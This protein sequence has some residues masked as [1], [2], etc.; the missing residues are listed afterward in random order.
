MKRISFRT[1]GI[2]TLLVMVFVMTAMWSAFQRYGA[3]ADEV[4]SAARARYE[5]YLLADE[6]RQSSDDL[7]RLA[8]TYVMS[9]DPKWE[10][11][12]F[13][14]LDI[15][16]GKL[17]RPADY[18]RIYWDFRAADI[19]PARGTSPAAPLIDLMKKAG[20]SETELGK[21]KIAADNSDDLV[22][23][24]TIAM[25]LVKGLYPDA[26]GQFVVV[27]K[28]D[29]P[30]AQAM[31]HDEAYHRYKAKIMAPLDEFF[32]ALDQRT[33]RGVDA[34][35]EAKDYWKQVLV[36]TGCAG[37]LLLGIGACIAYLVLRSSV[38]A[39]MRVSKA[40]AAGDL[41]IEIKPQG[42]AEMAMLLGSLSDT[43]DVLAS[44]LAAEKAAREL[45][46]R[47]AAENARIKQALDVAAANVMLIDAER[48]IIYGNDSLR[49]MFGEAEV[50]I[51]KQMPGFEATALIGKPV[52]GVH[53]NPGQQRG[54][55]D[56]LKATETERMSIGRRTFDLVMTPIVDAQGARLGTVIEWR[57]LTNLLAAR[58]LEMRVAGEN[59]QI[60]QALDAAATNVM[61]VDAEYKV[62]YG[63]DSLNRMFAEAEVDLRKQLPSFSA[64][65]LIGS[66]IDQFYDNPAEQ[67]EVLRRLTA[68]M[69]SRLLIQGRTFDLVVTPIVDAQNVRLGT[70]IE[71]RDLTLVLASREAEERN[72]AE[73]LRIRRALDNCSIN[74]MIADQQGR[75]Q[76]VNQAIQSLLNSAEADLRRALPQFDSRKLLGADMGAFFA[77]S[78][79]P[80]TVLADL[81]SH[82]TSQ[83]KIGAKTFVLDVNPVFDV[84]GKR[85]GTMVEWRD[86]TSELTAEQEVARLV[87][88]AADGDFSERV[89]VES[90]EGFYK[91]LADGLNSVMQTSEA[92]LEDISRVLGALAKGD[93]TERITADY[94]GTFG[95]LKEY[96]NRTVDQLTKIANEIKD[97]SGSIS[98][99]SKEIAE[100]NADLSRRTER[101]AASLEETAASME[102]LTS[103][104]RQNAE[105]ANQANQLAM[106]ASDV[107]MRGGGVVDQVVATMLGISESSK[108]IVDII[109]VI[110]GIAF[111]TNILAL[112][113]AVEAA[114]AGEQGRGFAVV[115]TEV[116]SLAQRSA[117]SAK[118]IKALIEDS[119]SKVDLGSRLVDE[120]GKTMSEIV[121]SVKRVTDIMA[122]ITVASREQST[123]IEQVNQAVTQMDE[124]TQQNASL[125]EE[126]AAAAESMEE[127]SNNLVHSVATFRTAPRST[128]PGTESRHSVERRGPNRATNVGRIAPPAGKSAAVA[129]KPAPA[130]SAPR[131][132]NG[133]DD[134]WQEF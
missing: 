115:A 84:D 121:T 50:D 7:T 78:D 48:T 112:N 73:N 89:H 131:V 60:K 111:Q 107:A 104:V 83:I 10:K 63:N 132:A 101:Q 39:A 77:N 49:A 94:H 36:M 123:G 133:A 1:A 124:V 21:L 40:I 30:K 68:T 70:V 5:S 69:T 105:N 18:Q 41:D 34:A 32:V 80:R 76:Y 93:L 42:P 71:W 45:E 66:S 95:R 29:L 59:A 134:D 100:G 128:V 46:Q 122:E 88:S 130:K 8:R 9:G 58:E 51:R 53:P 79:Q 15:R 82:H 118:E 37:M 116:R 3:A 64:R 102:E 26:A 44:K 11:Q 81:R 54:L 31:M 47:V 33:Q 90:M 61:L 99:A 103:T 126:A 17:P 75:I 109:G 23:T 22:R 72:A 57:D 92:A 19:D 110:D 108:K 13:E 85:A 24:E 119:V 52:D 55:L 6:L 56:R 87:R 106:G 2:V 20:F 12:Y 125:V 16:N 129:S 27:G 38:G 62:I 74:M 114:R 65:S 4:S 113:A 127:Q 98:T 86:R 96:G 14:I 28:P 67:R 117:E 97:A 25:N 91:Q 43:K 120:A 35:N